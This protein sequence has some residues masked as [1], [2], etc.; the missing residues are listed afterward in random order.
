MN[1]H[2]IEHGNKI[3]KYT[4]RLL[5]QLMQQG[6]ISIVDEKAADLILI[7]IDD[8]DDLAMVR[9]ARKIAG[10]RPLI[11]GGFECF[12][13][14]YLLTYCD[15]LNVGEG[16]EFF[17]A[18][19]KAK[20]VEELYDLPFILTRSKLR[21]IPSTRIDKDILPLVRITS[22]A[23]YY[24]AG[25]GCHGKCAFCSTGFVYPGWSN[26]EGKIEQAYKYAK[27][28]KAR[29]TFITNDSEELKFSDAA[30]S[31]RIG[32]YLKQPNRYRSS[33][34]HFGIEGFSEERRKYFYKPIPDDQLYQLID[35]LEE[36][37]Q[38]A[39][40]FFILNFPNTYEEMMKF[41][42]NITMS[43][44]TFPRIFIK[45]TQFNPCPHTPLWTYDIKQFEYLTIQQI[46]DFRRA[47]SARNARFR[48]FPVRGNA[49]SLWRA[50]IRR[51]SFDDE[52]VR[53]GSDP[54]S[55]MGIKPY[56]DYLNNI[57][58]ADLM[59]YDGR[60]MPSSQIIS[61]HRELRDKFA[62]QRGMMPV[63]YKCDPVAE[64]SNNAK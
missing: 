58:L 54:G 39:E 41:A 14:E 22:H 35:V 29:I 59:T 11:A 64:E 8:P 32:T 26:D 37:R 3:N 1:I 33:L 10:K 30:Q 56:L 5:Y 7:S 13:G 48:M 57:G 25:R 31:I 34:L 9:R 21:I 12:M 38:E 20:H 60:L 62:L 44:K 2:F 18:L 52:T 17:E 42:E 4:Y 19:G 23:Y 24:L 49:R 16:F 63:N 28:K 15:A 61:P 47:I 6:N 36:Q 45:L 43:A 53:L 27:D 51:C 55:K 40:F 50:I 46:K